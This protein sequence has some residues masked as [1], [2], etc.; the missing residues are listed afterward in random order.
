[1]W[2]VLGPRLRQQSYVREP[3]APV[4]GDSLEDDLMEDEPDIDDEEDDLDTL[5]GIDGSRERASTEFFDA[6]QYGRETELFES[7]RSWMQ[8]YQADR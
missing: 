8:E 6:V 3:S 4:L 5:D 7:A 1:M 2:L